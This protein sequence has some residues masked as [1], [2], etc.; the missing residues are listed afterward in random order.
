MSETQKTRIWNYL[1]E[2]GSIT[3]MDAMREF[4]AM[5]LAAVIFELRKE[6]VIIT[7]FETAKNRYGEPV[8]YARYFLPKERV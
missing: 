4:G 5:R 2:E 8:T 7:E 6:H 1:V 3:P